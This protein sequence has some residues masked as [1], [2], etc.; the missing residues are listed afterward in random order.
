M[1]F[2]FDPNKSKARGAMSGPPTGPRL[3]TSG[4]NRS[5][6]CSINDQLI[7]NKCWICDTSFPKKQLKKVF[8]ISHLQQYLSNRKLTMQR[9]NTL[10]DEGGDD[11]TADKAYEEKLSLFERLVIED[12]PDE[13]VRLKE[14]WT[15]FCELE[16]DEKKV[17]ADIT[18]AEVAPWM[19]GLCCVTNEVCDNVFYKIVPDEAPNGEDGDKLPRKPLKPTAE[20]CPPG[21]NC[22]N[23]WAF[24]EHAIMKTKTFGT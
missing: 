14:L 9:L 18:K 20:E 3:P 15:R 1:Q 5:V 6:W 7:L 16:G 21:C 12:I 24:V 4:G 8:Q 22:D 2:S 17:D 19:S 23:P 10:I 11:M 13:A